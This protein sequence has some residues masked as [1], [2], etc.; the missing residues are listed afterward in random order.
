MSVR[1]HWR[2]AAA[3]VAVAIMLGALASLVRPPRYTSEARLIVGK[4]SQLD[5]LAAT[6]GLAVAG[7]ELAAAYSRLLATASVQADIA[8]RLGGPIRGA[9]SGSPIAESPIIQVR[10]TSSSANDARAIANAGARALVKAVNGINAAQKTLGDDLLAE[11]QTADAQQLKDSARL[12]DLQRQVTQAGAAAT[13]AQRQQVIDAQTQVDADNLKLRAL[14][15]DFQSA[16]TPAQLNQQI[17]Q[18]VG[19]A[20]SATNDRTKFLEMA[21]VVAIVAGALVGLGA[22]VLVDWRL[23]GTA[24]SQLVPEGDDAP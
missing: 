6:P 16:L 9:V 3:V 7:Q 11:Y 19:A 17:V 23:G 13:D 2:L 10:A 1:R 15:S 8:K 14:E 21:L 20:G 5:N 18:P 12:Q 22:A 4:T 24:T